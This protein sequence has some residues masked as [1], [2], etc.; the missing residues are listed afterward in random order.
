MLSLYSKKF[1]CE[2]NLKQ[3]FEEDY[4]KCLDVHSSKMKGIITKCNSVL[5]KLNG[6]QNI[7]GFPKTFEELLILS[8]K[9]IAEIYIYYIK[10]K[11]FKNVVDSNF[12]CGQSLLLDYD[13]YSDRIVKFF[14]EKEHEEY[15]FINTCIY[16]NSSYINTFSVDGKIPKRQYDLDHF[17]PKSKCGLFAFSLYN[18]IPCCQV[19]NSRIK[20]NDFDCT[21]LTSIELEKLFPSSEKYQFEQSLKFRIFP[22]IRQNEKINFPCFNYY[23]NKNDFEIDFEKAGDKKISNLYKEKEVDKF[24]IKQRYEC[25]NAEFL[26]YI[27]K[28]IKYSPAFFELLF[29]VT[30][31]DVQALVESIFNIQLRNCEH[32]IFQK[33]YNDIDE[34][35]E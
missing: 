5:Q 19:C 32:Q 23:S 25:H 34:L 33:I 1:F 6:I 21:N 2:R 22:K 28:H 17:I 10:D 26:A 11:T 14:T 4:L 20:G 8:P 7:Q 30:N 15:F 18:L 27:D 24:F 29:K 3:K 16:C 35:F 13:Y 31:C 9:T 12:F